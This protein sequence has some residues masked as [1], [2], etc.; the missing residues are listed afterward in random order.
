MNQLIN[1][2]DYD[3]T[4]F[5]RKRRLIAR[6]KRARTGGTSTRVLVERLV[7][8]DCLNRA[9]GGEEKW[10]FT[11]AYL[12]APSRPLFML[13]L[14]APILPPLRPRRD[15]VGG[16]EGSYL[17]T[18]PLGPPTTPPRLISVVRPFETSASCR[19]QRMVIHVQQVPVPWKPPFSPQNIPFYPL[20]KTC[21]RAEQASHDPGPAPWQSLF[22]ACSLID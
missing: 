8:G 22:S 3:V 16:L 5:C 15:R 19:N 12:T 6:I 21:H 7:D 17:H 4:S 20:L 18:V 13:S 2:T 14:L 11:H 10:P 9:R 1:F